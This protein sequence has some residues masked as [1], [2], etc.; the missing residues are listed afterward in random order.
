MK[1]AG[2]YEA[3]SMQ[4]SSTERKISYIGPGEEGYRARSGSRVCPLGLV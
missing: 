4:L 2:K 1:E 3:G